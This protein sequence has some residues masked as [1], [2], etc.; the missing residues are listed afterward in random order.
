MT[1]LFEDTVE[2]SEEITEKPFVARNPKEQGSIIPQ[3]W[4]PTEMKPCPV[5][6]C[7][8]IKKDGERCNRWS[9]R[10]Y[11]K[12]FVHSGRGNFE[13]V[14]NYIEAVKESARLRLVGNSDEAVTVLE[15]LMQPGTAEAVRLRAAAEVLDRAGIKGP[16]DVNVEVNVTENPANTLTERLSR[17]TQNLPQIDNTIDAEIIEDEE[18]NGQETLF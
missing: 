2:I 1:D 8:Q 4:R 14:N 10:G 11:S 18:D 5:I 9:L 3:G 15:Q 16:V 7:I 6:Q 13:N 17:L 12:C